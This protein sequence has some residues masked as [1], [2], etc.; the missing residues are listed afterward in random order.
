M[1]V[2]LGL[3]IVQ[4]NAEVMQFQENLFVGGF[5]N[6]FSASFSTP[7]SPTFSLTLTRHSPWLPVVSRSTP[8]TQGP[9]S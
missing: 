8:P 3:S 6:F 7:R 4:S 1:L 2:L 9:S 5:E